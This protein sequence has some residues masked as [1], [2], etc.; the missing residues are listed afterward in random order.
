MRA[1]ARSASVIIVLRLGARGTRRC[2]TDGRPQS[3]IKRRSGVTP[4]SSL[5]QE[6]I[7][8][9][10]HSDQNSMRGQWP[11]LVQRNQSS[12][13]NMAKFREVH[14]SCRSTPPFLTMAACLLVDCG[15][16]PTIEWRV[17]E[18]SPSR[19]AFQG[20]F[21]PQGQANGLPKG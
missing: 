3:A 6:K 17:H 14:G 8:R 2:V 4:Q 1:I 5:P 20:K 21:D 19:G 12:P 9:C 11:A 18:R 16:E 10:S 13:S 15:R 7:L